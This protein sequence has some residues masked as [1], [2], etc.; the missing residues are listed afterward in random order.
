MN[1]LVRKPMVLG[2]PYGPL[3]RQ[4]VQGCPKKVGHAV[5]PPQQSLFYVLLAEIDLYSL[6]IP[7]EFMQQLKGGFP[8]L[9]RSR[10]G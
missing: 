10:E 6:V 8:G 9:S 5:E 1:T 2:S 7:R 3:L 4:C